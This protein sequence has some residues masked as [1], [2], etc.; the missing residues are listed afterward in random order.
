MKLTK[1][2]LA[3]NP[4]KSGYLDICLSSRNSKKSLRI[5]RLVAIAFLPNPLRL[6]YV[7]H[8]NGV[9]TDNRLEN[10]EW[11]TVSENT[12]HGYRVL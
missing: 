7:N 6:P 4:K 8:R 12:R 11:C 9:K 1:K 2:I 3:P 10:L 5:H